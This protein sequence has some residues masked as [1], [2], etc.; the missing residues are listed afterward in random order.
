[1]SARIKHLGWFAGPQ[2]PQAHGLPTAESIARVLAV[3]VRLFSSALKPLIL[4]SHW[5]SLS[6]RG[7]KRYVVRWL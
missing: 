2:K 3:P 6:D 1:M 7:S 4:G 5:I